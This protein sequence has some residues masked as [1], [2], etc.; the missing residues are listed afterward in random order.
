MGNTVGSPPGTSVFS[1]VKT[2]CIDPAGQQLRWVKAHLLHGE[3]GTAGGDL[4]GPGEARN[5]IFTDRSINGKMSRRV[6]RPAI[7]AVA[8]D[9][10]LFY[11]VTVDHFGTAGHGRFF[12]EVVHMK[13]GDFDPITQTRGTP[14]FDGPIESTPQHQPPPCPNFVP[15]P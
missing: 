4:H 15:A 5:L 10:V 1:D 14:E 2:Q 8:A 11:E 13:W 7:S 6:E 3:T 9:R 12:G